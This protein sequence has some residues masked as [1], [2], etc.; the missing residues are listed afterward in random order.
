MGSIPSPS[1]SEM[2]PAVTSAKIVV[3]GGFGAGKTTLVGS[4]S[5]IPPVNTEAIMT[6]ASVSHD[7]LSHTPDKST[8]TVAMDFGRLTIEEGLLLYLFGTPGQDRFWFM[9]EDLVRGALGAVV[10]ADSRRLA[11]SFQ[12]IDYFEKHHDLPFLVALNR[13]EG[14][15][16]HPL[17]EVRD[18]LALGPEVPVVALDARSR[19]ESAGVLAHLLRYALSKQQE[20][21]AR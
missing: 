20:P 13:F 18:A 9:W 1:S 4:V 2:A 6:E 8:T 11:D 15:P 5:E 17:D 12:A 3:A 7:D 10:L 16:M 14:V 19:R 21:A